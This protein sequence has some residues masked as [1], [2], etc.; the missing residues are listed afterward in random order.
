MHVAFLR[1]IFQARGGGDALVW[2]DRT[3]K[4]KWLLKALDRASAELD[5]SGFVGLG[6]M[7]V[8]TVRMVKDADGTPVIQDLD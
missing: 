7:L 5:A 6:S 8:E 1:E 4:Y 2:N 3:Y